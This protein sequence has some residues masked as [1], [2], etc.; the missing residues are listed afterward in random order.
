MPLVW[1]FVDLI[2]DNKSFLD[3]YMC[4]YFDLPLEISACQTYK[5]IQKESACPF[6]KVNWILFP[7]LFL[8]CYSVSILKVCRCD[9]WN[10]WND[11]ALTCWTSMTSLAK[12]WNITASIPNFKY[13][14]FQLPICTDCSD[15]FY[16]AV[17]Y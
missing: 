17:L 14:E 16:K 15:L 12:V 11:D 7:V 6:F 2:F 4:Q 1:Y 13:P 5:M 10:A 8:L 9:Y 3:I